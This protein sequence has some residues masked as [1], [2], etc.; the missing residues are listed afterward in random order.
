L[1]QQLHFLL[2]FAGCAFLSVRPARPHPDAS[3]LRLNSE[4]ILSFF[5]CFPQLYRIKQEWT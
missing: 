2:L 5:P 3:K 4:F 1:P